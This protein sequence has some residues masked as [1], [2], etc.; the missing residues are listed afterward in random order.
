MNAK[1]E[2]KYRIY[3]GMVAAGR[4]VISAVVAF[5]ILF[6]VYWIFISSI[7]PPAEL[8]K[9]PIDYLPDHPTLDSYRFLIDNVGLLSKIGSTIII[10]GATLTIGTVICVMGAYGFARFRSRAVSIGFAFIIA[11][12]LIPEVITA[13]PLYEFMQKVKLF[14]TYQG[15]IILYIS[16]I[17]PFTVLILR[18]FVGEIPVSLEEAASIDGA[19]FSQRLFLIVL[20]LMKPAIAT[21]CIINFITC[22]NNFFT[23]LYYSNGIQV[24][25]V[26]IVQLP[27]RDNMYGVPWDLVS[28][29]GWIILLPI[30]VFVAVFEKQIMDGIMAGGVKS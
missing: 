25:S 21:V 13:R 15:L 11:T 3:R 9:M 24:L 18:N 16:S 8:F 10:I 27:L 23:P 7:T 2:W 26:A 30:I 14:D 22:L 20:P 4:W 17:I 19:N 6:P 1:S 28:A 5:I 29:M 12:M